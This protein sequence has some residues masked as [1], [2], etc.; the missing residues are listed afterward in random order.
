[1]ELD[2]LNALLGEHLSRQGADVLY[3]YLSTIQNFE[4]EVKK[5]RASTHKNICASHIDAI[6]YRERVAHQSGWR[7]TLQISRPST[8]FIIT[9]ARHLHVLGTRW[10]FACLSA[11]VKKKKGRDGDWSRQSSS[12]GSKDSLPSS[13]RGGHGSSTNGRGSTSPIGTPSGSMLTN[14]YS[15]ATVVPWTPP[16]QPGTAG[17]R[18]VLSE[19]ALEAEASKDR[20]VQMCGYI[21]DEYFREEDLQAK[22]LVSKRRPFY[23]PS[24]QEHQT[25]SFQLFFSTRGQEGATSIKSYQYRLQAPRPLMLRSI[26]SSFV[27]PS[28]A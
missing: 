24:C 18:V 12:N 8:M 11:Q 25:V 7:S 3:Y 15:A 5:L 20:I 2:V 4:A 17:E 23:E 26:S 13:A 1:M 10:P 9:Q 6:M 27:V 28:S 21:L 14:H 16:N 22:A 19:Q